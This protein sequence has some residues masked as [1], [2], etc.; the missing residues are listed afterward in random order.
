MKVLVVDDSQFMRLNII[1]Y[2]NK[3]NIEVIGQA[4]NGNEAIRLYEEL[5]PDMVTMDITMPD[6]DGVEAVREIIKFDPNAKIIM[7]SAM[8]QQGMVIEAIKAGAKSFLIKPLNEERMIM[9][10]NKV[11]GK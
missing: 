2:L 11:M 6:M 9:E 10:I 7:C 1:N 3:N 4:S 8:G 5:R